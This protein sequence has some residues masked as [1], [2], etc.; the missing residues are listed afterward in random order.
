[1]T[2]FLVQPVRP[3]AE[4]RS[5]AGRPSGVRDTKPRKIYGSS[6][7]YTNASLKH[8]QQVTATTIHRGT[9]ESMHQLWETLPARHQKIFRESTAVEHRAR[10]A[11]ASG[12]LDPGNRYDRRQLNI[13]QGMINEITGGDFVGQVS[14][15]ISNGI[16]SVPEL[17]VLLDDI[18][19]V[20]DKT[21][22]KGLRELGLVYT[23][24]LT[25]RDALRLKIDV[26]ASDSEYRTLRQLLPVGIL[27]GLKSL[28]A[29]QFKI[30]PDVKVLEGAKDG[31]VLIDFPASIEV[32]IA[33]IA[34]N[35]MKLV[36]EGD[37][38]SQKRKQ[39][40]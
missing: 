24:P 34:S 35:M 15:A 4:V 1:M 5:N 29:Y 14:W 23:E 11:T 27:P 17:N 20:L 16:V 9:L 26:H 18:G 37:N 12:D 2:S 7:G 33:E 22:V 6:S 31:A 36:L 13:R 25:R 38:N 30:A 10:S 40:N 32:D 19:S 3:L 21:G 28:K 39:L 8:F